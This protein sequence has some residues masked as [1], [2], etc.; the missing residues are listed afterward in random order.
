[1]RLNAFILAI[2]TITLT[3]TL[4]YV[5]NDVDRLNTMHDAQVY[6]I[7]EKAYLES[8]NVSKQKNCKDLAKDYKNELK[9]FRDSIGTN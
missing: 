2:P 7:A 5:V 1:M 9:A 3:A 8:C 6:Q 4:V